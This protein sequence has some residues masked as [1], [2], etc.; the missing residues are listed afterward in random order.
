MIMEKEEYVWC[1]KYRPKTIEDTILPA[2]MKEI[3]QKM[4]ETKDVPNM[5][6]A[7]RAGV[8]KTTV[9]RALL[10]EI[11]ADYI[12][13]N[14]SLNVGI[15][16]LRTEITQF[17][18]SVSF[19]GGRKFVILDEADNL[20]VVVQGALRNFIEQFSGNCGF[21]LTCN[22][23]HKIIEPLHSRCSLIEFKIPKDEKA[24]LGGAFYKRLTEI[25][26]K[27]GIP[28]DKKVLGQ[29]LVKY[30]PDWRR[31]LNETQRYAASGA[32][33][34]GMLSTFSEEE[35]KVLIDYM[36]DQNFTCI[37]KWVGENS[38]MDTADLFYNLYK[39]LS[40]L[41]TKDSIPQLVLILA[42]YQ[43]KAAFSVDKEINTTACLVEILRDCTFA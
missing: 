23:P 17:A 10:E 4:V 34:A 40:T 33:D 14:G 19:S 38:D 15:D 36:K 26:N 12:V 3:F 8:G 28:F 41:L 16:V 1:E 2:K 43:F 18:S 9:A 37:R 5:I 7:G 20:S 13:R 29:A 27:E 30:Y 25:L 35:L 32:I 22:Y 24:A 42:E 6:L 21:I 31:L 39:S 11:G